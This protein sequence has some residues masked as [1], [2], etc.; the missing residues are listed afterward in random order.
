M[1]KRWGI[2]IGELSGKI[3]FLCLDFVL[4]KEKIKAKELTTDNTVYKKLLN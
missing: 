3:K 1:E 4:E 2:Q